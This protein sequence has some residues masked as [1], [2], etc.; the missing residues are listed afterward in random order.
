MIGTRGAISRQVC[1]QVEGVM[2]DQ[3][4]LIG[5][6][7]FDIGILSDL[8]GRWLLIDESSDLTGKH[9]QSWIVQEGSRSDFK[10]GIWEADAGKLIS[11]KGGIS[12][13]RDLVAEEF[14]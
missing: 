9:G 14:H 5:R 6:E 10:Q 8:D 11:T 2:Q 4:F 7:E 1:W 13:R 3:L 12:N